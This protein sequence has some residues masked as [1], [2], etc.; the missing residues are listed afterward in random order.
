MNTYLVIIVLAILGRYLV[1]TIIDLLNAGHVTT[2]LPKEFADSYDSNSYAKSQ[3]YLRDNARFDVITDTF[4]TLISL[5]F[6]LLGG[7]NLVDRAARLAGDGEIL[8]G[9]VFAGIIMLGSQLLS[10]P[11]SAY[12][13][14][15][16]EEKYGFNK[17]TVRTFIL[18]ILKSWLI[19]AIIGIP[20]FIGTLWLFDSAGSL[21][22]L[23]CWIGI[24]AV[25]LFSAFIAPVVI[26]PLFN[27]F[28]P[29]EEGELKTAVEEYARA[30]DFR[31]KGLFKID[32]SRRSTKTNAFF[33]GFGKYRRIAL[34]DTLIEK[35]TVPELVSV[36]AH[37]MGHYKKGH[38]MKSML[39][40]MATTGLMLFLLSLFLKNHGLFEAFRMTGSPSVYASLFF[41]GYLFTPISMAI[42]VARSALSRKREYEADAYAVETYDHPDAMISALK[43]LSVANLSNLTPHPAKVVLSYS[44]PPVLE[45]IRAIS[46]L[47]GD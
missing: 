27:K 29:L 43:K 11:L 13:T 7:F 6:V 1:S 30:H 34:F 5:L 28:I 47:Q 16:I 40:S 15:V 32:G 22:W 41:F 21:A 37:E 9:L 18:D 26:M 17:T 25:Q 3:R 42:S 14:F 4:T 19:G 24:T 8:P 33:T 10:I 31:M 45:R 12:G 39:T 46:K 36:L 38:I 44:H 20:V 35:H 2:D 23:Y